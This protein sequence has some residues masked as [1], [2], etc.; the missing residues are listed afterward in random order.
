MM[1]RR[2]FTI[3]YYL[4]SGTEINIKVC[5]I[6]F[7]KTLC[8]TLK[9]VRN[10][11]ENKRLT[12][13]GMCKIDYR[14]KHINHFETDEKDKQII[15]NHINM[16]PSFKSQ[17]SRSH[18]EK[19]YLNPDLSISNIYRLYKNNCDD[20]KTN[21]QSEPTYRKVFVEEYNLFLT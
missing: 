1:S 4:S 14:G 15:R 9:E 17:Y 7:L 5:Q 20:I 12:N 8:V 16:F 18:T 3:S 2:N 19:K 11:I 13:F 21:A 6:M 10:I